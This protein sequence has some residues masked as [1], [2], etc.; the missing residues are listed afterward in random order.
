MCALCVLSC[1][2]NYFPTAPTPPPTTTLF[3]HKA[4]GELYECPQCELFPN[5]IE[6]LNVHNLTS[7]IET[8]AEQHGLEENLALVVMGEGV[9][10]VRQLTNDYTAI[11]DA[12]G[13]DV[14]EMSER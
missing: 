9:R 10:V 14:S 4:S 13:K 12:I 2:R 8:V 7:G 11:R 3:H 5:T 1:A 6:M